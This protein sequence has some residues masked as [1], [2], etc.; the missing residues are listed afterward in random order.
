[1]AIF[2]MAHNVVQRP[3]SGTRKGNVIEQKD[4]LNMVATEAAEA[5]QALP[6]A[7]C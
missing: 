7:R 3:S 1:M 5:N 4:L 2:L 6:A